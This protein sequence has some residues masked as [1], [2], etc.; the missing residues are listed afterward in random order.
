MDAGGVVIV[1]FLKVTEQ[2]TVRLLL[3]GVWIRTEKE[4]T[5]FHAI[6]ECLYGR[7]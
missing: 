7:G 5:K 1:I 4:S 6:E 3:Q 2:E